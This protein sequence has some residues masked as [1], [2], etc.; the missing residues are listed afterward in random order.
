MI[1]FDTIT[2]IG[3]QA[4]RWEWS[5][6]TAPYRIYYKGKLLETT[7]NTTY[8]MEMPGATVEPPELEILDA[9]D[10]DPAE[11]LT[12]PPRALLQWRGTNTAAYYDIQED[13]DGEWTT[14]CRLIDRNEGYCR[15]ESRA[16]DDVTT[17]SWRVIP[18][19]EYGNEGTALELSID[20]VRNPPAPEVSMKYNAGTGNLEIS[21]G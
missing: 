20:I 7:R 11:N 21:A 8:Q 14:R 10:A 15:Y 1:A 18:V 9:N 19:D 4:W 5:A 17:S 13:V 6:T 16:L 3:Y 2:Q 12:Y